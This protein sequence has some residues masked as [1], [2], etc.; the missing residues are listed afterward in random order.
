MDTLKTMTANWWTTVVGVLAGVA[1]YV[2]S[3]G[4]KMPSTKQEWWTFLFGALLAVLGI[5]SKDAV[6]GSKPG[7]KMLLLLLPLLAGCT[8]TNLTEAI[9]AA[10]NDNANI[11]VS[12]STVYGVAQFSRVMAMNAEV[13]C[14]QG[15]GITVKSLNSALIPVTVTTTP[16][17]ATIQVQ[18]SR[19]P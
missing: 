1:Y 16:P 6:T 12:I 11:C 14:P 18:P 3:T 19:S 17:P 13:S 4:F 10:A 5:A 9:K 8:S 15:G 7:A 2:Q